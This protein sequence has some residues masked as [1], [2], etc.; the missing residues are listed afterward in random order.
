[1]IIKE[2][3][4]MLRVV[5]ELDTAHALKVSELLLKIQNL[6][7]KQPKIDKFT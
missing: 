4:E 5:Q 1:M 2:R 6:E 3:S 7:T